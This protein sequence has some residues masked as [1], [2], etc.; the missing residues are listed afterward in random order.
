MNPG[1][2]IFQ[3]QLDL[4]LIRQLMLQE[5][6]KFLNYQTTYLYSLLKE[7]AYNFIKFYLTC[8]LG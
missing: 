6:L 3:M 2:W 8:S 4:P 1:A 7:Y 5:T